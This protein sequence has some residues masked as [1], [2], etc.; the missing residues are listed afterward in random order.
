MAGGFET[1]FAELASLLEPVFSRRDLRSNA[2][3]YLRALLMPGVSGNCWA[4]AQAVGHERPYRFQH[5][6]SGAVWDEDAVRDTVRTFVARHL[7]EGGVLIFDETGDLKKGQASAGAGRQYTG[8]AGRVE[9]AI[10]AVYA[11]YATVHGHALIDRELYVQA[12][13]FTDPDRM[14]VAGFEADHAFAAKGRIARAQARRAL[15]ARSGVGDRRRGLRTQ[16]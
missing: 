7:G 14:R 16:Q 1:R 8:T 15:D 11:S 10:V 13:W 4:L 2:M 6:P 5:L 9:N 12:E 3:A